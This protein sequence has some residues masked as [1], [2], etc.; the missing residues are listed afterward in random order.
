MIM[1][2]RATLIEEGGPF[3]HDHDACSVAHRLRQL[4]QIGR[5]NPLPVG[6]PGWLVA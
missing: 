5:A 1:H 4:P 6:Q 3:V 2:K